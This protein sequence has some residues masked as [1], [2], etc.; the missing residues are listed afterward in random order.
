MI[1]LSV[2]IPAYNEEKTIKEILDKVLA[3]DIDKEVIVVDDGSGDSTPE[4]LGAFEHPQLKVFLK[5]ENEGKG[6][7]VRYGIDR[8]S[9]K[10]VL[11]QDADMEYNPD[12][13]PGLLEPLRSGRAD[14]V[15]GNRFPLGSK[16]MFFKQWLANKL[17]THL[18]NFLFSSNIR[19]ME[20]CYKVLPLGMLRS[21]ELREENFDI[22]AEISAKL[23]KKKAAVSNVPVSYRGR[24]YKEGK[25][26]GF[27]DLL[28]AV[29]ILVKYR[30]FK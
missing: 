8:A 3:V 14:A 13:Y 26:I 24:S 27:R 23:L 7:A 28:R 25:K 22:E 30:F 18:T 4:I 10:Y 11:I 15:Y 9:G 29:K 12:D 5:K 17:L 6:A 21:L 20:T 19:D 2:V 1:E 16:N